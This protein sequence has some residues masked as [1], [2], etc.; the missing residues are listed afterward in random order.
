MARWTVSG[1]SAVPTVP[2]GDPSDPV[3][4]PLQHSLGIDKFGVN[5]FVATRSEQ[6]LVEEHDE[7]KSGQQEIYIVFDGRA[8]FDVEG[9]EVLVDDGTAI[10]IT[11]PSV[12]RSAKAL[13]PGTKLL[14]VGAGDPP[15]AS[16]WNPSHFS[17]IPRPD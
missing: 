1:L 3:W 16:T 14:I 15:F 10:A 5:L 2:D 9:E 6:T 4:Y 12:R 8:L 11:D 7:E 13:S 17:N